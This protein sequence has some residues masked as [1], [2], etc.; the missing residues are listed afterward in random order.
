M[1]IKFLQK[2]TLVDYAGEIACTLFTFGCNFRCGFCY[3]PE[4]VLEEKTPDLSQEEILKF[5]DHRKKYLSA[6]CITGGE[7]LLN[8]DIE[9]LQKIKS[10]GY[11]IKIDTNGS[12]PEKLQEIIDKKLVDFVAMDI[13]T[14][15][16]NYITLTNSTIEIEKIEES[17]KLISD[18]DTYEFR[19]T[20]I[21]AIHKKE[22]L[23]E[24]LVWLNEVIGKKPKLFSLQGFKNKGK[25]IDESFN[26]EKDATENFLNE[27]KTELLNNQLS[28]TIQVK[29]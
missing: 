22:D 4:L 8:I 7:P 19:T 2:T 27:I 26:R 11:K 1:K 9:F 5:L 18:L 12:F 23:I 28:E 15:K 24:M 14:K 10:L 21:P 16:Q 3:N 25:F 13:K 20:I 29:I 6:I 17:M